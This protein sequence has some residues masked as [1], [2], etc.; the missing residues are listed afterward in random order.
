MVREHA[1]AF[2]DVP[3]VVL[4]GIWNRTR[5]RAETIAAEFGIPLVANSA[6]ELFE[7][8]GADLAVMA[9]LEPGI[10]AVAR[11][12]LAFPW[13][14]LMEKPPGIHLADAREIRGV[15]AAAARHVYVALNRRFLSSTQA[16]L[17]DVNQHHGKRFI[18]VQDQQD[19]GAAAAMGHPQALVENWMFANSIHLVDY[20]RVFGRGRVR[21]IIPVHRWNRAEPGIV[22]A[23]IEF[24]SGDRGLYACVWNGPGPWAVTVATPAKRWEL[25][26]LEQAAYQPRGERRQHPVDRHAW[27]EQFKPGFRLQAQHVIDAVRGRSSNVCT[28]DDAITTMELIAR[29]YQNG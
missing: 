5:S 4:S 23:G 27:D 7:R 26:P 6:A 9:V 18:L 21:S 16:V 3:G 17:E 15:A 8:T 11:E 14:L 22:S 20:L 10:N 28:L 24:E 13:T 25:R 29:I 1:R 19:L 2:R 12:C